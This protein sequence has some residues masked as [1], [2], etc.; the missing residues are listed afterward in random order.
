MNMNDVNTSFLKSAAFIILLI[1]GINCGF[2]G[3]FNI[4]IL[5]MFGI[6]YRLILICVGVSAA[7]LFYL[8]FVKKEV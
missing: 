2:I 1:G 6:L 8:R 3:L 7:Y 5:G 4:N